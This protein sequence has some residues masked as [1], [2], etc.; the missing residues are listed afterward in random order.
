MML[1]DGHCFCWWWWGGWGL[2]STDG[3]DSENTS[4]CPLKPSQEAEGL[5]K[6]NWEYQKI[7]RGLSGLKVIISDIFI[8]ANAGF[9]LLNLQNTKRYAAAVMKAFTSAVKHQVTP[10]GKCMYM[11]MYMP[12]FSLHFQWQTKKRR[13][14]LLKMSRD[15]SPSPI[16]QKK[17]SKNS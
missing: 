3:Y 15:K 6:W 9:A 5:A 11:Y 4:V 14:Q 13:K 2:T 1:Y 16:G 10:V 17:P 8:R 7:S 12:L